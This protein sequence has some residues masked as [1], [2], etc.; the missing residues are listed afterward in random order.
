MKSPALLLSDRAFIVQKRRVFLSS[1]G[2][3]FTGLRL[4]IFRQRGER[5]GKSLMRY[6]ITGI[7]R[8]RLFTSIKLDGL[9]LD[10][11]ARLS[12]EACRLWVQ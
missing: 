1:N 10:C 7:P 8:D 6:E 2:C 9:R 5:I 4:L 12:I 11:S 3:R